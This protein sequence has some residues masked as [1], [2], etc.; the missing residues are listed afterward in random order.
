MPITVT[1]KA[2]SRRRTGGAN[3]G[4][5]LTFI[6]RGTADDTEAEAALWNAISPTHD[7]LVFDGL[8]VE[9]LKVDTTNAADS[10]W[11][12]VVTYKARPRITFPNSDVGTVRIFGEIGT[13]TQHITTALSE[14][15]YP[16]GA[17]SM[18]GRINDTGD[19]VQ[20]A[21]VFVP[22]F[23]FTVTKVWADDDLP[24]LAMLYSI[25][26]CTNN[27]SFQVT[28]SI[29]G[30]T[31]T[32]AIG[33]GLFLGAR[34]GDARA[35]GAVEYVYSFVAKP[36]VSNATVASPLGDIT[37]INYKGHDYL[38]IRYDDYVAGDR[39]MRTAVAVY[40]DQVYGQAEFADLD[41]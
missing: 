10:F 8:D 17:E 34:W 20:G 12:G 35:D 30:Q 21:D 4:A 13:E 7:G 2:D 38:W 29:T 41:L 16:A 11:D 27:D 37:G 9:P 5:I 23:R 22:G 32:L 6:I 39:K 26:S 3:P 14:T 36:N 40:I 1:E 19:A 25:A 24:S 33:E 18:N 28:D 15:K 31:I